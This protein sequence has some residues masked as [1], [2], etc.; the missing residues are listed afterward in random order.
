M[1]V[2]AWKEAVPLPSR[3][4]PPLD[5][6]PNAGYRPLSATTPQISKSSFRWVEIEKKGVPGELYTSNI[7]PIAPSSLNRLE[8]TYFREY[9]IIIL[10]LMKM[11]IV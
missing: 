1:P 7:L 3:L 5:V 6:V 4:Y 9:D 11:E 8:P 10:F 2:R